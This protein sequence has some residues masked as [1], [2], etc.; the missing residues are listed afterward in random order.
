[1]DFFF[2]LAGLQ[3]CCACVCVCVCLSLVLTSFSQACLLRQAYE[4]RP[5]FFYKGPLVISQ[6]TIPFPLTHTHS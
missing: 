1:M 5:N 4:I 2:F 3:F 6:H